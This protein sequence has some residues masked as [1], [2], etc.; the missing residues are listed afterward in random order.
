MLALAGGCGTLPAGPAAPPPDDGRQPPGADARPAASA[1][2]ALLAQ[3]RSQRFAGDTAQA[4]AT[5]DRAIRIDPRDPALWLELARVRYVEGNWS[6]SE[7]LARKA[8]ALSAPGS[9]NAAAALAL[10]ADALERQGRAPEAQRL[11]R[12]N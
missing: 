5:L 10:Q 1:T 2:A 11:R 9:S 3:S 6:Q 4:S 8:R 12:N 7:Q